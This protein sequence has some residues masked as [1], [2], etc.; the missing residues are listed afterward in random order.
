MTKKKRVFVEL[1]LEIE[2]IGFEGVAIARKDGIVHFV[3]NAVPGDTVRVNIKKKKKSYIETYFLEL[4]NPS[5]LRETPRCEHFGIC[6]GCTWQNLKYPEQIKWKRQHVIDAFE[7]L[8][9]IPFGEML[10]TLPSPEIFHYRNKMDFS[11]ASSRWLTDEE[12]ANSDEI[13]NKTFALGLH[14]PGRFDKIVEINACH[15]QPKIGNRLLT[16]V[17]KKSL[18]YGVTAF[19]ARNFVGFLRSLII[20]S[21]IAYNQNMVI[22][23]TKGNAE[24]EAET[25]FMNWFEND[26]P[27]EFPEFDNIIHA[28]N[29]TRSPVAVDS[30]KMIRGNGIIKENILGEDYQ[31]SPFSFFQTN[32]T[33][34]NQFI[35]K[36][37]EFADLKDS[38]TVWDLYC[39]T[40]SITL[41]ASRKCKKIYGVELVE[42]SI[43]DA[44]V[45]AGINKI[46]NAEFF[47][48]DLHNA[49]IP[50]LLNTLPSP[51][52]IVIDPPRAG[53]HKNLIEHILKVNAPRL[54]YVSCNPATQARDCAELA[55]QY[56]VVKVQPVD[57]FPHTYH[58]ESI[59]LLE[60]I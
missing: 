23:I 37:I 51:D 60:R 6:G 59:A 38:E 9:K 41:P 10:E 49:D 30:M 53:V 13:T 36:I 16:K 48:A 32:A 28:I 29:S 42:S 25:K 31:I 5:P 12:V 52:C 22:L 2:S 7:R 1:E 26:F 20:R 27:I 17:R 55:S 39:G 58:V 50:E 18:E 46:D 56:K 19:D 3:K 34:L 24:S 57:M 11:F 43:A 45:N 44:K 35:G 21:T 14:V 47:C 4:L 54:V 40:G 15:I 33:Q 8:G